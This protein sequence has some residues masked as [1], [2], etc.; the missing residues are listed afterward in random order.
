[1]KLTPPRQSS[2]WASITLAVLGVVGHLVPSL[3]VLSESSFWLV[4]IGFAL[5]VL[6]NA[7]TGL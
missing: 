5:L 3:P 4:V 2:F 7:T 1:M 6:A